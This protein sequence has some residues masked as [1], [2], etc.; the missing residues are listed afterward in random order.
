MRS[1]GTPSAYVF[2]E[3][4]EPRVRSQPRRLHYDLLDLAPF[5]V[6]GVNVIAAHVKYYAT[7]NS[8]WMPAPPTSTLGKTGVLVFEA[9]LGDS[10][11]G[12]AGWIASD[13]TWIVDCSMGTPGSGGRK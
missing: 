5:L 6:P 13:E 11:Q 10:A 2:S 3:G 9:D 4:M 8:Y 12:G 7:P 1:C